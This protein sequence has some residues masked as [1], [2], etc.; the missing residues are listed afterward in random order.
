MYD[1]NELSTQQKVELELMLKKGC[2][3]TEARQEAGQLLND[4]PAY[5]PDNLGELFEY[6]GFINLNLSRYRGA[7]T[8]TVAIRIKDI[9]SFRAYEEDGTELLVSGEKIC[10][11]HSV[12]NITLF[13]ESYRD[14]Y[15]EC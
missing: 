10:V 15:G 3:A 12:K 6:S 11:A 5:E 9:S 7:P 8:A 14:K 4:S 13:L 2:D 1:L